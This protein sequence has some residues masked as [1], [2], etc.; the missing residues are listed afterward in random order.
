MISIKKKKAPNIGAQYSKDYDNSIT[1]PV[2]SSNA[3]TTV[4]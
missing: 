2:R 4:D 3:T 1:C